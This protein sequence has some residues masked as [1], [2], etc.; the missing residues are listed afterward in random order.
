MDNR[1]YRNAMI[2]VADNVWEESLQT[3]TDLLEKVDA[4]A[5]Q[6]ND[7][8]RDSF[9][10]LKDVHESMKDD[11]YVKQED[12]ILFKDLALKME[13]V[14]KFLLQAYFVENSIQLKDNLGRA[15]QLSSAKI[16]HLNRDFSI[17]I[18]RRR[19]L[20][21]VPQAYPPITLLIRFLR[22]CEEHETNKPIDHI[23]GK[24]SFGNVYTLCS[25]FI[26]SIYAYKEILE[27]WLET[28]SYCR[29]ASRASK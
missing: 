16:D 28:E 4:L 21:Y 29:T 24:H 5:R 11:S 1:A 8:L 14:F 3:V 7:K 26:L 27:S 17:D 6:S 20:P 23:T 10:A 19:K 9:E 2:F 22:N 15:I 13:D 12:H 25:L 18:S